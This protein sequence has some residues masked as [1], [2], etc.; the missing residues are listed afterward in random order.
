MGEPNTGLPMDQVMMDAAQVA[1]EMMGQETRVTSVIK[2]PRPRITMVIALLSAN[3]DSLG[4]VRKYHGLLIYNNRG[5]ADPAAQPLVG[6]IV[7]ETPKALSGG[8]YMTLLI[9]KEGLNMVVLDH[10]VGR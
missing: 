3:K 1:A 4:G 10:E 2:E 5:F 7:A 6:W 8:R 9:Y